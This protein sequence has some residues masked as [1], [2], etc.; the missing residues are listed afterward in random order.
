MFLRS[1]G[2]DLSAHPVASDATL[3]AVPARQLLAAPA[4]LAEGGPA[5]L[6]AVRPRRASESMVTAASRTRAVT[7]Y[8]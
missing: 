1:G 3:R 6:M 7:M 5:Q 4:G 2:G 8:W